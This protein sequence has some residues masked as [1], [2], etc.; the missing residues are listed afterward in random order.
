MSF[1]R[2]VTR[3][4]RVLTRERDTDRELTDEVQHYF[5]LA[6][7]D[8]T[9]RGLSHADA[10]RAAQR[11]VGNMTGVREQV[12]SAGWESVVET[13]VADLR[14]SARRLRS[15][16]GFT[17]VAVVTLALGIG[18]SAAIFSAIKPVLVDALPY[19]HADRVVA[20]SDVGSDG[21]PSDVTFG[22]FR[23]IV[24]RSH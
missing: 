18:A 3:G 24:V 14:Y 23:E 6:V 17:I 5:D 11:E 20:L 10:R 1:W 13:L 15:A 12:R 9:K 22:T 16:P 7:S 19:P 8:W 4:L 21:S 2:Q